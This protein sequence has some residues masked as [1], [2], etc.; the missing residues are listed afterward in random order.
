[1]KR[2][3]PDRRLNLEI[4]FSQ[5][6]RRLTPDQQRAMLLRMWSARIEPPPDRDWWIVDPTGGKRR[7]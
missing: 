2:R 1:M 7:L 4:Q 3:R 5:Y 6:T